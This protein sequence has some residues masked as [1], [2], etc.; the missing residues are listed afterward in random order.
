MFMIGK[1]TDKEIEEMKT[2]GF[3]VEPVGL[4]HFDKALDKDLPD[5]HPDYEEDRYDPDQ[6][7]AVWCDYDIVQECRDIMKMEEV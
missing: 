1:A 3:T 2:L 7:V 4:K 5:N 6:L